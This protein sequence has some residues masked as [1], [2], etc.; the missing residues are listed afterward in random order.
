ML[1]SLYFIGLLFFA[2]TSQGIE[3]FWEVK[4]SEKHLIVKL[5]GSSSENDIKNIL[6]TDRKKREL[7]LV[8]ENINSVEDV[9]YTYEYGELMPDVKRLG[10]IRCS[11]SFIDRVLK[12]YEAKHVVGIYIIKSNFLA[13]T[14]NPLAYIGGLNFDLKILELHAV[15][16][17]DSINLYDL[18]D[19]KAESLVHVDFTACN[20]KGIKSIDALKNLEVL[21]LGRNKIPAFN[22]VSSAS[23]KELILS[24]NKLTE[25]DISDLPRLSYLDTSSNMLK[26]FVLYRKKNPSLEELEMKKGSFHYLCGRL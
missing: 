17:P 22:S 11:P 21:V 7:V 2:L 19:A 6:S 25:A 1:R 5:S 23:L 9:A 16:L 14:Q 24:N 3:S 12:S 4:R 18:G 20:I 13:S 10:F 26:K 15:D 8:F